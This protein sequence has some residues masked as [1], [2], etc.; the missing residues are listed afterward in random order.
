MAGVCL[1]IEQAKKFIKALKDGVIEPAKLA[2]M[3]SAERTSFFEKIVGEDAKDVN[4]LFESKLLLKNQQAGLVSWAKKVT[5]ITEPVRQDLITKINKMEKVLNPGEEQGFLAALAEKKLGTEIT[6]EEGSKIAK[7][8]KEIS[9]TKTAIDPA[10]PA[11][12][13]ERLAYGAKVVEMQNYINELK[14][15]NK[16]RGIKTYLK[17]LKDKPA[18]TIGNTVLDTFGLSKAINAAFDNSLWGRQGFKAIFTNP[19][20]WATNFAKSWGD[21][22]KQLKLK[23]TDNAVVDAIKA[24]IYSRP[25]AIDGT[26]NRMKLD[27]GTMEE[28]Y[29]TS[30]PERIPILGRAF[31]ASETAYTGGAYRLRAD[32]A[33]KIIDTNKKMGIDMTD[34]Y[35]AYSFGKV[36]NSLTG[37][38]SLG[39]AGVFARE[40]NV[41][42]FSPKALK[43]NFDFLTGHQI[44]VFGEKR[45]SA[46]ARKTARNNLIKVTT[47][48][49]LTLMIAKTLKPD[50]VELD[51]RSSDFGKIKVGNTTFDVTGGLSS[52]VT[53]M[54]REFSGSTKSASTGK[55]TELNSGKY[56][57]PTRVSV[58]F[59][60]AQNKLSPAAAALN[61]L[62]GK[63]VTFLGEKATYQGELLGL[64][65]PLPAKNAMTSLKT[66]GAANN[67]LSIVLDALGISS[68]SYERKNKSIV[69]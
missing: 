33:D 24:D 62:Y 7:L 9:E 67:I 48:I 27:I 37:R 50:S 16:K 21:I 53:L 51:P 57:S 46:A 6:F 13:P 69:E 36:V 14:L 49:A 15:A 55:V 32:I 23:P 52:L 10:S 3:T 18:S 56:N 60:F 64:F 17:D 31:K 26:Y 41:S 45:I 29:P 19:K 34:P 12:S 42:L 68:N 40:A 54:A 4:A 66:P 30:L 44:E 35:E 39:K 59:D 20:A 58:L 5:G 1:P 28:A 63:G 25:N 43:A 38:G 65:T 2:E 11:R 61:N 22:Y 8:S 47:G